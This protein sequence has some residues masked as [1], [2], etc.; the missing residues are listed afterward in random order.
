MAEKHNKHMHV[1]QEEV[2][3]IKDENIFFLG[4]GGDKGGGEWMLG[5]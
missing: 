1:W 4:G 3:G 2:E 5:N